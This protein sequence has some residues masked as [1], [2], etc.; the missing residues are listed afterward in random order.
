MLQG[1]IAL[2]V[3]DFFYCGNQDFQD[4]IIQPFKSE[5][6]MSKEAE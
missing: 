3:D 1:V 5:Y 2:H 4:Q 6:E